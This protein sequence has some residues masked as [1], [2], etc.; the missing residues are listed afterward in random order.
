[1][2]ISP[3]NIKQTSLRAWPKKI[4]SQTSPSPLPEPKPLQHTYPRHIPIFQL[5]ET[6]IPKVQVCWKKIPKEMCPPQKIEKPWKKKLSDSW[7]FSIS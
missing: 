6:W 7:H 5:L 2:L 4:P 1:L 3:Q